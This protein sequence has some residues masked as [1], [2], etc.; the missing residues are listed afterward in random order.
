MAISFF[1]VGWLL[2]F[3]A[4]SGCCL[5]L[6][7]NLCEIKPMARKSNAEEP[8]AYGV[9]RIVQTGTIRLA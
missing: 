2:R 5:A 6:D 4:K 7:D 1:T 9:S 3:F 8:G